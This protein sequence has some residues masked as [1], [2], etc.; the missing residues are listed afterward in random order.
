MECSCQLWPYNDSFFSLKIVFGSKGTQLRD[1]ERQASVWAV[2]HLIEQIN[3]MRH[4]RASADVL[5]WPS[6]WTLSSLSP[7]SPLSSPI[8]DWKY[9]TCRRLCNHLC[10]FDFLCNCAQF[11]EVGGRQRAPFCVLIKDWSE[12][13]S[14]SLSSCDLHRL[15]SM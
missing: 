6:R 4:V 2:E 12:T 3:S 11:V 10:P 15:K 5:T 8:E 1:A 9:R 14:G 7:L 13:I